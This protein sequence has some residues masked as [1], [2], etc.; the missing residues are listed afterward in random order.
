VQQRQPSCGSSGTRAIS[1]MAAEKSRE[2][3]ATILIMESVADTTAHRDRDSL[4]SAV[5]QLLLDILEADSVAVHRLVQSEGI[6]R[7]MPFVMVARDVREIHS[8][9]ADETTSLGALGERH[10]WADCVRRRQTFQYSEWSESGISAFAVFPIESARDVIGLLVIECV[11][12]LEERDL[13][14]VCSILRILK[15]HIEL[16][17]YGERD[18]LTHMLN[19]KTFESRFI[20]IREHARASIAMC[21]PPTNT[22]GSASSISTNSNP[23]MMVTAIS[24]VTKCYC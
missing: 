7:V 21:P 15:N 4:N 22:V 24:L 18:T 13:R 8:V 20:K 1:M 6:T 11:N 14:L 10:I 23:S 16:L 17:D 9:P 12:W 5:A 3:R 2:S 19:C